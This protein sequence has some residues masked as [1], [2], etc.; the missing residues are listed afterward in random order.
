MG[1]GIADEVWG[2][3][4]ERLYVRCSL[5][6]KP[7]AAPDEEA[8]ELGVALFQKIASR[9]STKDNLGNGRHGPVVRV[10]KFTSITPDGSGG[11]W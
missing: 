1:L 7:M 5:V 4:P 8:A 10:R 2:L 6:T 9:G 11:N 3:P